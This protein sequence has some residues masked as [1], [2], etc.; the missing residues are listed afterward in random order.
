MPKKA[1]MMRMPTKKARTELTKKA[2]TGNMKYP[3]RR[4][5]RKKPTTTT[6]SWRWTK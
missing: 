1:R 2:R 5:V 3:I 6:K 4:R